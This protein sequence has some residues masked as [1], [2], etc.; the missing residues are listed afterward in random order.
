MAA[1]DA[2]QPGRNSLAV[3]HT[4]SFSALVFHRPA[5]F[6][7]KGKLLLRISTEYEGT[8]IRRNDSGM[9]STPSNIEIEWAHFAE[10][11]EL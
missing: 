1:L 5:G 8:K 7:A 4:N 6:F 3:L 10:C 9:T 11:M 2:V